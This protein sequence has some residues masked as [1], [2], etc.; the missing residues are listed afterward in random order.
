MI[1]CPRSLSRALPLACL[2]LSLMSEGVPGQVVQ[3][4]GRPGEEAA[5]IFLPA[6]R[7]LRQQLSRAAKALEEE[8]LSEAVD[9]LG[10]LLASPGTDSGVTDPGAEQDYFLSESEAAGTQTSLKSEAQRM[11]GSMPDKG[12]ELYELKFGADARQMLER[13]LETRDFPQLV[14]VTRRYFHTSAG[15]EA[16]MLIGRYYFDQGRPLAAAMRFERLAGSPRAARQ[17]EPEL[18]VLLATCWLMAEMPDRARETLVKLKTSDPQATLRIGDKQVSLFQDESNAI[19]WLEQ[20]IGPLMT[21]DGEEATEWVLFRGNAA[22]NAASLGGFPLLTARWR[23]RAANHPSDEE[24]IRQQRDMFRDQGVPAIPTLQP[25][26]VSNVIIVRTPR[27]L[28]AIDMDSGK[29]IWEF[30]WFEDSDEDSLQNDP[31]PPR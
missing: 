20:L 10:Q 13:A 3:R 23:V 5:D 12:R 1:R 15:Y 24:M 18:S 30:P 17:Y 28:V 21:L 26:A 4:R 16:T 7:N 8:Q 19:G 29:R 2:L 31:V 22:R 11:L 9:L 27:R 25:L 6:P 14:E